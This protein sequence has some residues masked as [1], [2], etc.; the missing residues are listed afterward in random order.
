MK[1]IFG[2]VLL[3]A[4]TVAFTSQ[5]S[6]NSGF[7]NNVEFVVNAKYSTPASVTVEVPKVFEF[8]NVTEFSVNYIANWE[9]VEA[10]DIVVKNSVIALSS[11]NYAK[12]HLPFEVG[13]TSKNIYNNTNVS[14]TNYAKVHL[15]F[16]VG[17]TKNV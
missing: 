17:L 12:V 5:A 16:E 8:I 14:S 9:G 15:P 10:P 13:L 7:D 3:I 11:T 1:K 4:A 2:A 6:A